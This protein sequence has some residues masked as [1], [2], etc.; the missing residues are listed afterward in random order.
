MPGEEKL[1]LKNDGALE[2]FF[3]GTGSA[4]AKTHYQTNFLI[5]KGDHHVMVDFGITGP[6][7]LPQTSKLEATDIE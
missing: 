5:I 1:S 2:V 6:V 4:F 7:A 3:I